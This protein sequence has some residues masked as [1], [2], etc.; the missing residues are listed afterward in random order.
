M[1]DFALY[2][3]IFIT[4]FSILNPLEVI[5]IFLA[6][7]ANESKTQR[8]QTIKKTTIAVIIILL[9]SAYFGNYLLGFFGININ[10]FR[11]AGGILLLLMAINMLQ[12]KNPPTK[13]NMVEQDEA[14]EKEDVSVV[15]LAIPLTAG[16]GTISSVILFSS[17]M[18]SFVDKTALGVIVVLASLTIWPILTLSESIGERLG[19]T[20]LN[21]ATRIMGL[22]LAAIAVQFIIEGILAFVK[23]NA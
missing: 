7:T 1:L 2:L 16:P 15:P 9:L 21:V 20:G 12:A 13:T 17:S 11:I 23:T 10:S 18:H 5:P 8:K 6:I 3:H 19:A 22:I 14:I 4:I